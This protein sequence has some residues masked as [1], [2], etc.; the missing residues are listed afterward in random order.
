[1][2]GGGSATSNQRRTLG[3]IDELAIYDKALTA[4]RIEAHYSAGAMR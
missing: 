4:E 2:I 1:V 3:V